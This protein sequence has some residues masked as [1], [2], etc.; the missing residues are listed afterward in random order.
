MPTLASKVEHRS[1]TSLHSQGQADQLDITRK[2]SCLTRQ[3]LITVDVAGLQDGSCSANNRWK[4][5]SLLLF[6]IRG[7]ELFRLVL[8]AGNGNF[9]VIEGACSYGHAIFLQP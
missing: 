9:N 8:Y 5:F 6:E 2:D 3:T 4:S 1:N 7:K